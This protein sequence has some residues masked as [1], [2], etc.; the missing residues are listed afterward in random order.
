MRPGKQSSKQG[1]VRVKL[2]VRRFETGSLDI[3]R[4]QRFEQQLPETPVSGL[5][6]VNV[7]MIVAMLGGV[8]K[9]SELQ[10]DV[11]FHLSLKSRAPHVDAGRL[12][13]PLRALE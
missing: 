12:A 2:R 5:K 11:P 1:K 8:G 3:R 4:I 7:L 10:Q 6:R 13:D 9:V